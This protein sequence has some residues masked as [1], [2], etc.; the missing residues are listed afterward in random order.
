MS[1]WRRRGGSE[2]F[3]VTLCASARLHHFWTL[4]GASFRVRRLV[5]GLV[6][7][8]RTDAGLYRHSS[9]FFVV[10][11]ALLVWAF[12]PSY[13]TRLF[14]QPSFWFHAHG[15]ALTMWC[16]LL[17]VQAQLIRTGRRGW[18]RLVGQ[19]SYVLAPAVVIITTLFV[20]YRLAP[21][22]TDVPVLPPGALHF[23][24][25]TLISIVAFALFYA[26]AIWFRRDAQV[27]ARW[28]VCT[29]F[30]IVTPVTDRLIG[31]HFQSL[32]PFMPRID[33]SPILPAAGVPAHGCAAR[34]AG[35]VG[36]AGKSPV[37]CIPGSARGAARV[38]RRHAHA[39]SSASLEHAL[40]V[41]SGLA[42]ALNLSS[43][44]SPSARVRA[45]RARR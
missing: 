5:G 1:H 40:R 37:R 2:W 44:R 12:W 6:L 39:A 22:L 34:G 7:N 24:A 33:G 3:T 25:L 26:L 30:A 43:R 32:I 4:E 38:P 23:L 36:L 16:V 17:V 10:F 19:S 42:A 31:A 11:L 13:F 8:A 35:G 9:K 29:V 27:H 21:A 28:M 20:H 18:H 45:L 41:V 14:E 15:I